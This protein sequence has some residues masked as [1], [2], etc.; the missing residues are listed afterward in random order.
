MGS[1]FRLFRSRLP[2]I[3][4]RGPQNR[5][6]PPGLPL[7]SLVNHGLSPLSHPSS[8]PAELSSREHRLASC[9]PIVGFFFAHQPSHL[10]A[11]FFR[12]FFLLC[13]EN[14]LAGER[15]CQSSAQSCPPRSASSPLFPPVSILTFL[16]QRLFPLR[17][18]PLF[19]DFSLLVKSDPFPQLSLAFFSVCC[20]F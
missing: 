1:G 4:V 11:A 3:H 2:P 12:S 14:P 17:P 5:T 6:L 7:L 15:F 13:F 16:F 10:L 20:F 18:S 8:S 9:F 19:F